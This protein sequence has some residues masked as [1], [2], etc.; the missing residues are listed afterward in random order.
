MGLSFI[1]LEEFLKMYKLKDLGINNARKYNLRFPLK[2]DANL[3]KIVAYLTFDGHLSLRQHCFLYTGKNE[4]SIMPFRKL[5]KK[6]FGMNGILRFKNDGKFGPS[7]E[8]RIFNNPI[9]K[10]LYLAGTP[11]G[12]KTLQAFSIPKWILKNKELI[13]AYLQVAFDCEGSI[14][15]AKDGR[16]GINFTMAKDENLL[17]NCITFMKKLQ[18]TSS[19]F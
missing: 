15:K 18:I 17:D 3:A 2:L 6:T 9:T 19:L 16:V 5:I 8:L 14:W 4:I 12:N 1:T 7:C 13:R 11:N 10:L